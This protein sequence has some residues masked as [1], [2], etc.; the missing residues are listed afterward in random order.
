MFRF[1]NRLRTFSK[2]PFADGNKCI[3]EKL[4]QA[5]FYKIEHTND[6]TVCYYC[7]KELDGWE[8]EDDPYE[9]HKAHSGR[10]PLVEMFSS[11]PPE[12]VT[13]EQV[14]DLEVARIK[15]LAKKMI[16]KEKQ[17]IMNFVEE[18]VKELGECS[19]S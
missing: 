18:A 3:P 17:Q 10:C 13:V 5:G 12:S 7:E 15:Y 4:A 9:E 6:G 11:K 14:I 2:W 19:E 8:P 16:E 1:E